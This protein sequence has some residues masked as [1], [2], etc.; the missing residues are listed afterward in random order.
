[1]TLIERIHKVFGM[2]PP[3]QEP[4]VDKEYLNPKGQGDEGAIKYF[5]GRPWWKLD[6][7]SL[8]YHRAA[9]YMFTPEVLRYYLPAFMI[10][11]LEEP[12]NS[13]E[14]PHLIIW[15]FA[16]Y[17]ERFWSERIRVLT[18]EQRASVAK[19]IHAV[20]DRFDHEEG[21]V[22]QALHGL[23]LANRED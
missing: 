7:A 23:Q 19:F 5:S 21:Y 2:E 1:M 8:V 14:I 6:V 4:L 3:S 15:H 17:K 16:D 18:T 20:A 10:A 22:E 11:A 12:E 13:D 9:L